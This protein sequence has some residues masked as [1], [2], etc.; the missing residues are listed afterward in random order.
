MISIKYTRYDLEK[1]RKSNFLF[2]IIIIGLLLL[3]FIVGS[4]FFNIFMK[5]TS[6]EKVQN[7]T[8]KVN[9]V[10]KEVIKKSQEQKFVAIQ[11]GLFKNKDNL[12]TNK[13]KLRAFGEPFCIEEERGTRVFLGIYDE[14]EG[15]QMTKKLKENKIDNSKMTFNIKIE[16]QCD[17]QISETSKT[18]TKIL[19]KLNE[20]DIKSI[21]MKEF[22]NWCKNLE[23]SSKKCKN[24]NIEN[25]L[26][27]HINKLPDELHKES[28]TKEYIYIFNI[29][30]KISES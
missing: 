21:K 20:K 22:K 10:K 26:K 27:E 15:E 9:E 13:N 12:E 19:N 14:K 3:A 28:I 16:N 29:L 5:K 18:Y 8:N 7:S 17:A 2:V 4:A 11:G 6:E 1:R 25:E 24:S 23:S 30:S